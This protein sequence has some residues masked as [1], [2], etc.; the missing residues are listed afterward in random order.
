MGK[1]ITFW[2]P[3]SGQAKVTATMCAVVGAL[4]MQYPELEIAISHTKVASTDLEERLEYRMTKE[5]KKEV[6]EKNG[7]SSVALNYMQAVLTSEKIKRCAIPLLMRSLYLVPGVGKKDISAELLFELLTNHLVEEFSAVFLDL[8]SE[9]TELSL[10]L[11]K[12]AD[13]VIVVLPQY[14]PVWE[15]FFEEEN[16]Y[17]TGIEYSLMLGGYLEKTRYSINY[18]ARRREGKGRWMGGIPINP[19]YLDAMS[20]GRTLEFFLKNQWVEKKEENYEFIIQSKKAAECFYKKLF[21]S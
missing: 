14:L 16:S 18:F 20:E 12:E 8:G 11:M 3:Y 6:Y 21:V 15:Q 19:G 2:S 9:K 7:L 1:L 4:G 10:K 13:A 5:E 17:L